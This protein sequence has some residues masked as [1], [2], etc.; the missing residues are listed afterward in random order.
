MENARE[1]TEEREI[2]LWEIIKNRYGE[3]ELNAQMVQSNPTYVFRVM[4]MCIVIRC[5]H[6]FARDTFTYTAISP[7]FSPLAPGE[8]IPRYDV[9]VKDGLVAFKRLEE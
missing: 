4:S 8:A 3:F 5:E 7:N 1:P 6:L 2:D 9:E